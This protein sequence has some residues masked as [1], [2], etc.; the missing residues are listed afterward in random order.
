MVIDVD[1]TEFDRIL[2]DIIEW[3]RLESEIGTK[4]GV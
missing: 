2:R 1:E 4:K 3:K